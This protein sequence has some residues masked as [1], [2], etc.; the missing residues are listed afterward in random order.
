MPRRQAL[1]IVSFSL[2]LAIGGCAHQNGNRPGR[3]PAVIMEDEIARSHAADAY[4]VIQRLRG[5][6]F[7]SDR[8]PVSL[9]QGSDP[10]EPTVYVDGM[11]QGSV[12]IL[13]TL[14]ADQI[15]EIHLYRAWEAM[16]KFGQGNLGGVVAVTT[17][18]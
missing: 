5:N 17:K 15:A 1:A 8:G 4:S 7:H 14:P 2:I 3:D 11:R 18:H 13:H 9:N 10:T 16:T 6:F 12:A